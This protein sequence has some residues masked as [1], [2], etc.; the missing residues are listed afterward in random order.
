MVF[1]ASLSGV[2][3]LFEAEPHPDGIYAMR[4][5]GA[6]VPMAYR[7]TVTQQFGRQGQLY[8]LHQCISKGRAHRW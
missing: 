1:N 4:D 5:T 2:L 8:R 6:G 3:K 7:L